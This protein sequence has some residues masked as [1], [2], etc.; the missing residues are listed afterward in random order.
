M[1]V[2][3]QM[4]K[5]IVFS[6]VV[7]FLMAGL[8]MPTS[9]VLATVGGPTFLT[10]FSYDSNS[11]NIY[12]VIRSSSERGGL[13]E[14]M[15]YNLDS[16]SKKTVF[17]WDYR[18]SDWKD[19]LIRREDF[20]SKFT[21]LERVDLGKNKISFNFETSDEDKVNEEINK[22]Y[23]RLSFKV[24]VSQD[25][26]LLGKFG[27][28]ACKSGQG[29]N[30][31]GFLVP[32]TSDLII[33]ANTVSDCFEGGY[34]GETFF[35]LKG[36]KVYD[37]STLPNRKEGET[38][39]KGSKL[40]SAD[41]GSYVDSIG[42]IDTKIEIYSNNIA[43]GSD[44]T[45]SLRAR[46]QELLDQ[47]RVLQGQLATTQNSGT[48]W[49]YTFN[50]N[51]KIGDENDGVGNLVKA[52]T[53]EG[54]INREDGFQDDWTE[55]NFFNERTASIVS[56]F[57]EKYRSEILTP[58]GLKSGTGYVGVS[59]RKK[60]NQLYGCGV[61]TPN[62]S[63]SVTILFPGAGSTL[64][65]GSSYDFKW[66]SK[67]IPNG[68]F[69]HISI[70][71]GKN[72]IGL[73]GDIPANIG[74]ATL[75]IPETWCGG[76]CGATEYT[77]AGSGYKVWT[78]LYGPRNPGAETLG[79]FK[80]EEFSLTG[81]T[82]PPTSTA[83]ITVLSPNGGERWMLGSTNVIKWTPDPESNFVDAYLEKKQNGQFVTIG[84]AVPDARG[85][86]EW[87][88]NIDRFPWTAQP[89]D[90]YYIK[91]ANTQTGATDRSDNPF[92]LLPSG[93]VACVGQGDKPVIT[94]L[95]GHSG[96]V[97]TQL[98]IKGCNFSGFEGDLIAWI[99]NSQGVKGLLRG[100][101][102]S[103]SNL[104]KVTLN[105]Q[106]CQA[107]MGYK[108][109]PCGAWLTLVPGVYK[110]YTVPWSKKSNEVTFTIKVTVAP[111]STRFNVFFFNEKLSP[112]TGYGSYIYYGPPISVARSVS[113]TPAIA[114]AAINELLKGPTTQEKAQ[115]YTTNIPSQAKLLSLRIENGVAYADFNSQ[116]QSGGSS[117]PQTLLI[118][119][120][121]LQF[122]IITK[123]V[124]SVEGRTE[125][126]F[127]P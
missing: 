20:L 124:L 10:N 4:K 58:N 40:T 70:Y 81:G 45:Q 14:V 69:L 26:K 114:T 96:P 115:D 82:N 92:T 7:G 51:L 57:Q 127:Q 31:T 42:S 105:S 80:S 111:V 12:Y 13:P 88:G 91:L 94:S 54:F 120:T 101:N 123:V 56:G 87:A 97:G 89:G 71:N 22:Y 113:L 74:K 126:I 24:A 61:T 50:T 2:K 62:N 116:T 100:E 39:P 66:T 68:A 83:G 21:A 47:I 29:V 125:S 107:D 106:L 65:I 18:G 95:S 53:K 108:G 43:T 110:I 38:N 78:T 46:I 32:K 37:S 55:L 3:N 73:S 63:P 84:K 23:T 85:S 34:T 98:E 41:I 72:S 99:E 11:K 8:V 44:L 60:L 122:P 67:N 48:Q 30:F 16:G 79:D 86:I 121:L 35:G 59:T 27:L 49:C 52:L 25:S 118:E 119:K 5:I 64:R 36:I 102:G 19:E 112:P 104:L 17:S 1:E 76:E 15:S 90:G 33:L 28:T 109:S 75:K 103:T 77:S 9:R 117:N 93:G 6:L